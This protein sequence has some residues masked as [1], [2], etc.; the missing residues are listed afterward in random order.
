MSSIGTFHAQGLHNTMPA[1]A[2]VNMRN[3]ERQKF[4]GGP[5]E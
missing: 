5:N 4:G 2:G 3:F 1:N